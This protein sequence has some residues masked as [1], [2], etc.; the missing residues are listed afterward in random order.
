MKVSRQ[1]YGPEPD[2]YFERY[3]PDETASPGTV[4]VIHGGFWRPEFDASLGRPL[5]TDLAERG[6]SVANLEYRRPERDGWREIFPDVLAGIAALGTANVVAVGHSAGAQLA[7][8]AAARV[9]L[10]G[11][12]AQAGLLDLAGAVRDRVGGRSVLKLLG[13]TPDEVPE[14]Y[15]EADPIVLAPLGIPVVCVH[16]RADD[17]VPIAQCEA[18]VATGGAAELIE[19]P[20]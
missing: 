9:P 11:I 8:Y 13:G 3:L 1:A 5:A 17:W 2:Q 16:S 4:L 20:G 7:A 12:V 10:A 14:R 19:G 6:Y 15:R 18:Y